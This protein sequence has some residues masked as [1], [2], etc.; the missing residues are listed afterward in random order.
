MIQVALATFACRKH[1]AK[2]TPKHQI[3]GVSGCLKKFGPKIIQ[4]ALATS[5]CR[6]HHAKV[7]PKPQIWGFG[8]FQVVQ[9][10]LGQK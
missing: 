8:E 6:M 1:H 3:W 5:A 9:K 4:V 7:I 10:S 2:V